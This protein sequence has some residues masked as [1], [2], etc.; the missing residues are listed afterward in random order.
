L[1]IFNELNRRNVIRVGF[2]YLVMAWLIIQVA[3]T[4]FPLFGFDNTPARVVVILLAVGFVPA[5]ITAWAFELTPEG[6]KRDSEVDHAGS[7]V[8]QADKKLDRVIMVV[9]ALSL[10]FFA[11]DKFV[12]DPERDAELVAETA[13]QVRSDALVESYG[14]KSIAV[15]PFTD[16]S[17][18]GDQQYLSDGLAEELLNLL[19]R[20]KGLRVASRSSTFNL[21][22]EGLSV[23][24][25]A[26]RLNVAHVLE[27]SVRLIDNQLRVTVQLIEAG[28][29][30]HLWSQN[31]DRKFE[32]I[33]KIQDDIA[34]QVVDELK[35]SLMGATPTADE[36]DPEAY[37]LLLQA[38]FLMRRVNPDESHMIVDLLEQAVEIEPDYFLAWY[39]LGDMY[40]RQAIW[41]I[42]PTEEVLPKSR[43]ANRRAADL[44]PDS[45]NIHYRMGWMALRWDNDLEQAAVHTQRAVDL[46]ED[47]IM[48]VSIAGDLLRHLG[49]NEF[50]I[51]LGE[52]RV[53]NDPTD[54][55]SHWGLA[56]SYLN[57]ERYDESIREMRMALTLSPGVDNGNGYLAYALLLD[58]Q[59]DAALETA[60][61]E[62]QSQ[63]RL[64]VM[65]MALDKLGRHDEAQIVFEQ[66]AHD[67]GVDRNWHAE[68]YLRRGDRD[69][70]FEI[71]QD[72]SV[73]DNEIT[74][75]TLENPALK[76]LHSD[77]RWQAL[78]EKVSLI[79]VKPTHIILN[80]PT[81]EEWK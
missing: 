57:R 32:N 2:A 81:P 30:T 18:S 9:L 10:G 52:Y 23:S 5:L 77:P 38:R 28:S 51:K 43:E 80:V 29:D 60:A 70:A 45:A 50:E 61:K 55:Q 4:I 25:V 47:P 78:V 24:E 56:H 36:V 68:I 62:K 73:E 16:M 48:K 74:W 31:Y 17:R 35:V 7:I 49:R 46:T 8:P 26:T 21:R 20:V 39:I 75:E 71:L 11:F 37:Q 67:E 34:A 79:S 13:Q 54:A 40:Q 76:P 64:S 27:G 3:E 19:V 1:S 53:R 12:L 72:M 14:D 65:V 66:M 22:D 42:A 59:Y 63:P 41:D 15:L 58:G 44:E 33:F 69:K 6:L